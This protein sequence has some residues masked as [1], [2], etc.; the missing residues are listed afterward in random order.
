MKSVKMLNS[1][2]ENLYLI[3]SSGQ[4]SFNKYGLGFDSSVKN[5]SP[6]TGIKFVPSS[7]KVK[8]DL[9]VATKVVSFSSS[10]VS[11]YCGKRDHIRPFC[12]SL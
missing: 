12:Y 11:H 5:T 9:L 2:S 6:T 8:F 1:G 7:V 4:S 10:W 3:L